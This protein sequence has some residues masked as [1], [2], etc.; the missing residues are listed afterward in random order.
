[1]FVSSYWHGVYIGYYLCLGSVPFYLPVEDIYDKLYR[2]RYTGTKR[3][4]A[5]C[6]TWFFRT[7]A[8]SYM[9]LPFI[10]LYP[11]KIIRNWGSIYFMGHVLSII[12]YIVGL[13]LKKMD[14]KANKDS[15]DHDKTHSHDHHKP[16][17]KV[18]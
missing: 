10:Y 1:M 8:F 13:Q 4:I 7:F 12:G 17:E 11:S 3:K 2:Q 16:P 18:E 5:T 15:K 9:S 6:F 14:R